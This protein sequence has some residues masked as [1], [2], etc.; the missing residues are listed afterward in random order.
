M[1]VT[2][3]QLTLMRLIADKGYE[4]GAI[5]YL[6]S[7]TRTNNLAV[8][9]AA[10]SL[11]HKGLLGQSRSGDSRWATLRWYLTKDGQEFL[12]NNPS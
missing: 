11:V 1:T 6:R 3:F 12:Q 10:R 4:C 2:D 7:K 5:S 9:S 8:Y